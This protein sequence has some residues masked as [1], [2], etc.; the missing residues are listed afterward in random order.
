MHQSP[1]IPTIEDIARQ[2]KVHPSTV[3]R[4]LQN[5]PALRKETVVRIQNLANQLGYSPDPLI[6]A[7]LKRRY[8]R[9]GKEIATIAW[10]DNNPI[11]NAYEKYPDTFNA[12]SYN[13]AVAQ[14]SKRGYRVERFWMYEPGMT[15]DR[16]SDILYS[17]GIRGLCV[18]PLPQLTSYFPMKWEYFA[19]AAIGY[20]MLSPSLHR[21]TPHH[22]H[23]LFLAVESL[24]KAGYQRIAINISEKNNNKI[25]E[26]YTAAVLLCQKRYGKQNILFKIHK[27][28]ESPSEAGE[29]LS[30]WLSKHQPDVFLTTFSGN[31]FNQMGILIPKRT[32]LAKLGRPYTTNSLFENIPYLNEKTE[33]IGAAA[34]DVIIGQIERNEIGIPNDPKVVM[35]EGSWENDKKSRSAL[36]DQPAFPNTT[37][38]ADS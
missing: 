13:G 22:M 6:S 34:I 21:A 26:I 15:E 1:R 28:F 17:R 4:A 10:L 8:R 30:P 9:G 35:I 2:A 25:Q 38:H 5:H 7:L 31:I 36:T 29:V 20:S 12:H 32:Q 3:S 19:S 18:E 37:I 14:A 16:L 33:L 23:N 11:K 27:N 24:K